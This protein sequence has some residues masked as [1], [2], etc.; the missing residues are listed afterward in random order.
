M[1]QNNCLPQCAR[2]KQLSTVVNANSV[3]YLEYLV[4]DF[5]QPTKKTLTMH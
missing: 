2:G 1:Y 5:G 3:A 4:T